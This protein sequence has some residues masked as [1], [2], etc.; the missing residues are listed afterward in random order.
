MKI[1]FLGTHSAES[2]TTRLVSFLLDD[3]LAI[4][5]GSLVSELTFPEQMRIKAVL[6]THGHYDHIR[7]IPAL[8][9]NKT[10]SITRVFS[11]PKTLDIL[12]SHLID[13][14]IYPEFTNSEYYLGKPTLKLCPMETSKEENVEGYLIRAFPVQHPLAAVGFEVT[15][16]DGKQL[17]YT[18]DTGPGLAPIWEHVSPQ[19]LIID[20]TFPNHLEDTCHA[21]GHLC[22]KLLKTEL[23]AFERSRGY[24]PRVVAIHQNPQFEPLIREETEK[25]SHELST[26]ISIASE[27][28]ELTL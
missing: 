26:M 15:A 22:P 17:F 4:E 9:F 28:D 10:S 3:I 16:P 7:G 24:L 12:S 20:L 2:K 6:V 18:G 11:S 1:K 27:G 19:M 21:S 8:A 25:V 13:G 23:Q 14:I 5:A